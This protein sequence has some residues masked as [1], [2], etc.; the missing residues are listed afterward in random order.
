MKLNEFQTARI[1][2]ILLLIVAI[3]LLIINPQPEN[4]LPAGF[5][6]PV[7]AFEFIQSKQEILNFFKVQNEAVYE[8][9][10]LLGNWVDYAFM[11]LYSCLLLYISAGIKKITGSKTM[12]L[13]MFF[14]MAMLVGDAVENYAIYKLV[15]MRNTDFSLPELVNYPNYNYLLQML[16]IFTWLKW[17]SIASAFLLFSPF[18]LKGKIFHKIIGIFCIV[19]FGLCI[20]AF[21]QHG[22]LNEIFAGS[23]VLV[24]LLLVIFI[25]TFRNVT[26]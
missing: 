7:I 21:L 13:A 1:L 11:V 23:V 17:G 9:K 26:G 20:A 16:N 25:F 2:G 12:L 4:N 19:C 6:T 22:I 24:F 10:M 15:T 18:F 5:Y 3:A 8:Q 14:C